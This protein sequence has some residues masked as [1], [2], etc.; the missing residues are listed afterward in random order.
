MK[1]LPQLVAKQI[2]TKSLPLKKGSAVT[3]ETWDCNEEISRAIE[4]EGR[5]RGHS[6]ITLLNDSSSFVEYGKSLPSGKKLS[7]GKHE[8]SMLRSTD[9]YVFV[10]GPEMVLSSSSLDQAHL[11]AV[12][13]YNMEWYKVASEAKLRGV[14]VTAGYF[15]SDK[16]AAVLG[17]SRK[18]VVD[19][20][21]RASL[22]QP[23][24]LAKRG[25]AL[26]TAIRSG[27]RV[28][29]TSGGGRITFS[30]GKE[31]EVDDGR[32]DDQDVKA[33]N[34]MSSL[35]GGLFLK[36]AGSGADG[37][38]RCS[39]VSFQGAR[40]PPADFEFSGGKI[41]SYKATG[42]SEEARKGFDSYIRNAANRTITYMAVGL[43]PDLK[44]GYGRDLQSSGQVTL[45]FGQT[46]SA[47]VR[48]ATLASGKN[49]LIGDG[50]FLAR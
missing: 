10:P 39:S 15:N 50:K 14:R 48:K 33:K 45:W 41:V 35:P 20:L 24:L 11:R 44:A 30:A 6:V 22:V 34:N 40:T 1:N 13:S 2:F 25:K 49:E 32:T 3:V 31:T 16:A 8:T 9:A 5:L 19:H 28:S 7:L 46:V 26:S 29:I 36:Q 18:D 23:T 42:W 4:L 37:K 38:V 27:S 17:K 47:S 43:N 12:T 21:L